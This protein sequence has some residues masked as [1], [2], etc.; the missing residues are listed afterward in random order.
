MLRQPAE[1]P[2]RT[3]P[4]LTLLSGGQR[5]L[6]RIKNV[7]IGLA[8]EKQLAAMKVATVHKVRVISATEDKN[9]KSTVQLSDGT[10]KIV[11]VYL[12]C[13]GGI[14]NTSFLPT[15]W[16]NEHSQVANDE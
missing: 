1:T 6:T 2:T 12:D 11:E 5:L 14:P 13:T 15:A 7:G 9:G 16:L 10:T 8:A 3:S 4:N